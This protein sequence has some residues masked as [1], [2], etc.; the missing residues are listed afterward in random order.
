MSEWHNVLWDLDESLSCFGLNPAV[1]LC[2]P[3]TC[4]AHRRLKVNTGANQISRQKHSSSTSHCAIPTQAYRRTR[5]TLILPAMEVMT[6]CTSTKKGMR[7][8]MHDLWSY[9]W[10]LSILRALENACT[11][12]V[13][14]TTITV[15][16][17]WCCTSTICLGTFWK[18]HIVWITAG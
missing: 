13:V 18:K 11:Q 14:Y 9:S 12:L 5:S 16:D 17:I 10:S 1:P 15:W 7:V 2:D 6:P 8:S 4:Q 3:S